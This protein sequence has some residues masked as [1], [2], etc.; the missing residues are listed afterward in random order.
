MLFSVGCVRNAEAEFGF[1]DET[2]LLGTF[3]DLAFRV[4]KIE[5]PDGAEYTAI[6][7]ETKPIR[8][9]IRDAEF[10]S[11]TDGYEQIDPGSYRRIRVSADSL[12]YVQEA[13]WIMLVDTTFQ[14]VATAFLEYDIEAEEKYRFIVS[15]AADSWFDSDSAKLRPGHSPF[16]GAS[17]KIVPQY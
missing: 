12:Y 15:M 13:N 4:T 16:D 8:V 7:E 14:F 17:L 3:G 2:L 5:V 11:V 10:I 1:S 6:W 9:S